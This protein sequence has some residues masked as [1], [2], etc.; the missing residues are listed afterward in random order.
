[1]CPIQP[2]LFFFGVAVCVLFSKAVLQSIAFCCITELAPQVDLLHEA[3][4]TAE[5][6]EG[7]ARQLGCK[8]Y[9]TCVKEDINVGEV[10]A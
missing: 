4:M 3:A 7:M 9:R 1:M 6:V 5:E 10:S 8:L 2:L